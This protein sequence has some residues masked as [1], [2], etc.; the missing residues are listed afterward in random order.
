M[1][2]AIFIF[3]SF[4]KKSVNRI[5][6]IFDFIKKHFLFITLNLTL[7]QNMMLVQQN[8][9]LVQQNMMLVQQNILPT[10]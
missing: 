5:L 3:F 6:Y 2:L 7:Q 1:D 9:M 10:H 8:M 4:N